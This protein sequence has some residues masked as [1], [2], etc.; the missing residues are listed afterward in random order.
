MSS[1]SRWVPLALLASLGCN[2]QAAAPPAGSFNSGVLL[3]GE[4]A[5]DFA[6]MSVAILGDTDGDGLAE[7]AVGAP[8]SNAGAEGGGA[9]YLLG[10]PLS[11]Q[12]SLGDA[13]G[14]ILGEEEGA[15]L[16]FSLAA[17]GDVDGDGLHDLLVGGW[18]ADDAGSFSGAAWLFSGPLSGSHTLADATA[19]LQG[20]AGYDTAGFAI[21]G[22]GGLLMVGAPFGDRAGNK[23]GMAY[24]LQGP[25]S[26]EIGLEQAAA[27][28]TG[29]RAGDEAG[30]AVALVGDLNADGIADLAVGAWQALVE[31]RRPGA[32]YLFF[33]PQTGERS[34][35]DASAR[36]VGEQDGDRAGVSLAGPGDVD[37]D[38]RDDLLVG[39]WGTGDD[40]E[41]AG[42]AWL[43]LGPGTALAS[44]ADATAR[45][46]GEAEGDGAGAA[47]AGAGDVD[48]DGRPDLLV[49]GPHHDGPAEDAGIA[50]I[51]LA[52]GALSPLSGTLELAGAD[53]SWA[54]FAARDE[55]GVAVAGGGDVDGDGAADMLIGAWQVDGEGRDAGAA[56]VLWGGP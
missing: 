16:G 44:L 3:T 32:A 13:P 14:R 48:E 10:A 2:R 7:I 12:R 35:T 1:T 40:N 36:L 53:R 47:V 25:L 28:L 19:R 11:S 9:T 46:V 15:A 43:V 56:L 29:E 34:V 51:V 4:A 30:H 6:G 27:I 17:P 49:G 31:R 50:W 55:A 37:G 39:S 26:G 23:A 18:G 42:V 41:P 20:E 54:G 45:L 8:Y 52:G 33:G 5:Q 21:A 38:G 24:L 22:R